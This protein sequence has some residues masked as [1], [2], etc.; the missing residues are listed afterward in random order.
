[1]HVSWAAGGGDVD[2]LPIVPL[3]GE[4]V[5]A[6][7]SAGSHSGAGENG[8]THERDETIAADAG[9]PAKSHSAKAFRLDQFHCDHDDRFGLGLTPANALF[10][11]A[12]V[13]LIDLDRAGKPVSPGADHGRPEAMEH[14]PSR[15]V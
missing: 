13:G 9:Y 1:M 11:A 4:A 7:P 3:L 15:L 14:R 12:N 6:L 5:V 2:P 8:I 10:N